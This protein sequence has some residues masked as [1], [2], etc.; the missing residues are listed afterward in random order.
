[1]AACALACAP[2]VHIS[3]AYTVGVCQVRTCLDTPLVQRLDRRELAALVISVDAA[4][5][6]AERVKGAEVGQ[7]QSLQ[8][9]EALCRLHR[10]QHKPK[11][12]LRE[13][14]M[15]DFAPF[16]ARQLCPAKQQEE[17]AP[18]HVPGGAY[19]TYV[20]LLN[21]AIMMSTQLYNDATNPAHHKY[22][23]HQV[24]LLYQSLNMLQGDT[25]PIRRLIEA[26]FDEIKAIT[27]SARP[28]LDHEISAWLQGITWLCREEVKVCPSYVHR[29]LHP[30]LSAVRQQS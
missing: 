20:S 26:R 18:N 23:A 10:P 21:Q 9:I 28:F 30:M 27:E 7:S 17:Q 3:P 15:L 11:E 1:M 5:E 22:A 2:L 13:L 4:A 6:R 29:R 14:G 25:K 12:T 16:L 8:R 19:L 24:A